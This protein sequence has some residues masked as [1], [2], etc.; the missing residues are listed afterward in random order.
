MTNTHTV[1]QSHEELMEKMMFA[2]HTT[3]FWIPLYHFWKMGGSFKDLPVLQ[4]IL[5]GVPEEYIAPPQEIEVMNDY[6]AFHEF[7][8]KIITHLYKEFVEDWEVDED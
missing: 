8:Q 2:S 7:R 5:E 6:C 4:W 1:D 3:N